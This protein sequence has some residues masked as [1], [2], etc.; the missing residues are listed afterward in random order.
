MWLNLIQAH[1]QCRGPARPPGGSSQR[2]RQTIRSRHRLSRTRWKGRMPSG[3]SGSQGRS[4]PGMIGIKSPN[5]SHPQRPL[6]CPHSVTVCLTYL[7]V[8]LRP[9]PWDQPGPVC[10][11]ALSHVWLFVA[12]WTVA[13]QSPLSTGLPGKNTVVDCHFLLQGIFPTYG[14]NLCLLCLL[15]WQMDSLPLVPSGKPGPNWD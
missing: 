9:Q 10:A 5:P 6:N 3:E 7:L 2:T 13:Q 12:P 11:C 14:S 15:H 8:T 4:Q 1:G